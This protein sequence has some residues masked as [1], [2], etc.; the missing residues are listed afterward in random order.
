MHPCLYAAEAEAPALSIKLAHA[1]R[2]ALFSSKV[3]WRLSCT[4]RRARVR[5]RAEERLHY[6]HVPP[7]GALVDCGLP[8]AIAKAEVGAR[9]QK[10]RDAKR[11]AACG[12]DRERR[13]PRVAVLDI[14]P[15]TLATNYL[16]CTRRLGEQH[17][18][19]GGIARAHRIPYA[20]AEIDP[21]LQVLTAVVLHAQAASLRS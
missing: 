20:L 14:A 1:I 19:D 5:T 9:S 18:E 17:R 4:V 2:M 8:E 3:Q 10:Q 7:F 15:P 12:G 16:G 21:A 13:R 11:A 6:L